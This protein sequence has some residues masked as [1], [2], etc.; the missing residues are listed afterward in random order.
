MLFSG[1]MAITT[2]K[3]MQIAVL[4]YWK[5]QDIC[6]NKIDIFLDTLNYIDEV[7]CK[8]Y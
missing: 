8:L 3:L 5:I 4:E 2:F 7:N 6:H 1:K